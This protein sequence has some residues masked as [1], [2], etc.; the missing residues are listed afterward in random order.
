M[1]NL[2]D[3]A[4]ANEVKLRIEK[5]GPKSQRQWGKMNAAQAMAHCATTMEWA[6]GDNNPPRMFIGRLIGPLAKSKV[7]NGDEPMAKNT[8]TAKSLVVN[9]ERELSKE[10]QRL[11]ALVD[12]FASGGPQRCTKHPHT[13]FGPLKPDEWAALMYKHLDHHLRQ[14]G[15]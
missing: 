12:R 14:F 8:P 2:F 4:T 9:D 7:L 13:F 5:L 3:A 1:K 11:S 6:V 15:V 10:C